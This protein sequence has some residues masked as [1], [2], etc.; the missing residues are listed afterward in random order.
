MNW[1]SEGSTTSTTFC[2]TWFPF[3]SR[4]KSLIRVSRFW[5]E[6]TSLWS[7]REQGFAARGVIPAQSYSDAPSQQSLEPSGWLWRS[8]WSSCFILRRSLRWWN[9]S[10]TKKYRR[11]NRWRLR[12][13]ITIFEEEQ[14]ATHEGVR[15][16][17]EGDKKKSSPA[18]I[19]L[20]SET[21]HVRK[22]FGDQLTTVITA[23]VLEVFL[24]RCKLDFCL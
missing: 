20:R 16:T 18:S 8:D 11:E 21:V 19:H 17:W 10:T 12:R 5:G 2:I 15:D 1:Q 13:R 23:T 4:T 14:V 22:Q 24:G 9:F 7:S 6:R 3:W